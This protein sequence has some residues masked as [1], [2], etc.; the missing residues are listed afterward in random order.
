VEHY[1]RNP[2][3]DFHFR[4]PSKDDPLLVELKRISGTLIDNKKNELENIKGIIGYAHS[5]FTHNGNNKPTSADPLTIL[6]EAK[7]G[8]SFRCVEYSMLANGL[9]WANGIASRTLGLK[10]SDVET[11]KH[12][13][14][15]VVIEF[16]SND[17]QKWVMSDVQAGIIPEA[18]GTPLSAVELR[19]VIN[20]NQLA[21]YASV[22]SS[23]F[24]N[25]DVYSGKKNYSDWIQEYLY[26]IDT[27]INLI[28]T[29]KDAAKQQIAML[30]P[31]GVQEPKLFQGLFVMNAVYT[32]N[33]SDFYPVL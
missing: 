30:V 4:Y 15:H 13:A 32:H 2:E 31:E 25:G 14:G 20:M 1:N 10:T 11:R 23:R 7:A 16:W 3:I 26:F 17:L 6:R 5:L 21:V 27:P 8:Q 12:G 22:N 33:V 9:L 28:L 19:Q 24:S 29:V 18:K